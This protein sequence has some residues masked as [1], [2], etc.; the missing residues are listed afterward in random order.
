MAI[1]KGLF[2]WGPAL[3][4]LLWLSTGL[5]IVGSRDVAIVERFGKP[6]MNTAHVGP[7]IH[8]D[9]PWPVSVIRRVDLTTVRWMQLGY[10]TKD[11]K[12]R[13]LWTNAHYIREYSVLTGDGAIVDLAADLHY[14]VK[15]PMA[16]LY[17]AG[18]PEEKLL[19]IS[20]EAL[21]EIAGRR[22]LFNVLANERMEAEAEATELI[23][24]LSDQANL[25]LR[26]L[27][28]CFLDVHP[29][30]EVASSFEDVVSAQED[31]E[32]YVEQ[33][34]GYHGERIPLAE[35]E[36]FAQVK[37]AEIYRYTAIQHAQGRSRA[38]TLASTAFKIHESVNR[39]RK[40]MESLEAWLPGKT[41]WLI[42]SSVSRAM[43]DFFVSRSDSEVVG[44]Q[45]IQGGEMNLE[46]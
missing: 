11:R 17:S 40:R 44:T 19:M 37:N 46:Y 33:A 34:R 36:A 26:V 3:L 27:Q 22:P 35:A 21:R 1:R 6:V 24:I 29:P 39:H 28:I 25:G 4:L 12:D 13:I 18:N 38:Y 9:W 16:F 45:S 20:D 14:S 5:F 43:P 41:L 23:Q 8:Y 32:T 15:D 42:D 31:L 10:Q 2:R 30:M 7:G